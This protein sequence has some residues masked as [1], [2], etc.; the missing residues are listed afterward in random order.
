M[1]T[2]IAGV[3][4]LALGLVA[5]FISLPRNGRVRGFLRNDDAQAYYTVTMIILVAFGAIIVITGVLNQQ[6]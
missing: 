1:S 4:V 2:I 6:G 3:V 5:F